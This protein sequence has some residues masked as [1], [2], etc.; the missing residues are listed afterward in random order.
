MIRE[1][2]LVYLFHDYRRSFLRSAGKRRLHT[3]Q[4]FIDLQELI[5]RSYGETVYTNLGKPFSLLRPSLHEKIM[6]IK[7]KTQ[8]LYPKDI[9]MILMKAQIY[10]GAK[11]IESGAG[12]GALTTAL[13][14]FVRPRGKVYSYERNE[15]FLKNARA[16][17]EKNGLAEW[18]EFKHREVIDEY[19]E[20]DADFVMIDIGSPWELIE[21]A[22]K[23]LKGGA[24]LATI[25]PTFEQLSRTV[26]T[27]K[28]NEF[29]NIES[30]EIFLRKILVRPGKTRP[31][32]R[33]PSHTG[34]IVF[35]TKTIPS[36]PPA[37]KPE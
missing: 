4:G 26:F 19:E 33:M 11:V 10:P 1:G 21:P 28:E 36:S 14:N 7:R 5:G 30:M 31:E 32:Q 37:E 23:A 6:L 20:K 2:D 25:C 17:I 22:R 29:T 34:W 16:N 9:G 18:V 12:S 13:A 27:L 35:A 3:D 15:I 8:I 24:V